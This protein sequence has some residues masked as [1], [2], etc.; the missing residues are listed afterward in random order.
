MVL[1]HWQETARAS[2][3]SRSDGV[4][5]PYRTTLRAISIALILGAST[6]V[7]VVVVGVTT[8]VA[9]WILLKM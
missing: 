4:K 9:I 5:L 1:E 8:V 3:T 2:M 7:G 6:S